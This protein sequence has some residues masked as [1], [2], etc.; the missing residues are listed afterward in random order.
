MQVTISGYTGRDIKTTDI[1]RLDGSGYFQVSDT[2]VA[3]KVAG[4]TTD[5]HQVKFKG[6]ALLKAARYIPKGSLISVTGELTFEH[7]DDNDGN[8][9]AK[10]V[11]TV[12]EIQLPSKP[13]VI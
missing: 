3:V 11:V 8:L 9:H 6:D 5:W 13:K 2:A 10:P 1:P 7:W 4:D 12:A